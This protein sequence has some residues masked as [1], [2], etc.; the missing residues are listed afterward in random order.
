MAFIAF[1][2]FWVYIYYGNKANNYCRYHLLGQEY[3]IYSDTGKHIVDQVIT[4]FLLGWVSIPI[5]IIMK[6]LNKNNNSN[7]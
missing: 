4:A 6:I 3:M 5:M 7:T 1:I 2:L